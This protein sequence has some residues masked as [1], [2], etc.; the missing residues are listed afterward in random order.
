MY[1]KEHYTLVGTWSEFYYIREIV[2]EYRAIIEP[3]V[4]RFD[5][6]VRN[7]VKDIDPSILPDSLFGDE[8]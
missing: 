2:A 7:R 5:E 8:N 3:Y 6:E 1:A 4:K